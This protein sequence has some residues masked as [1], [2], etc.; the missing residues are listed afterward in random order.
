[1]VVL[2]VFGMQVVMAAPAPPTIEANS[3]IS[4]TVTEGHDDIYDV[5]VSVKGKDPDNSSSG[6]YKETDVVLVI[7]TSGSMNTTKKLPEA[8]KSAKKFVD[9][10]LVDGSKVNVAIVS[11]NRDATLTH[12]LSNNKA[13]LHTAIDGLKTAG[14]TQPSKAIDIAKSQFASGRSGADKIMVLLSDGLPVGESNEKGINAAAALPSNVIIKTIGYDIS[15]SGATYLKSVA[16]KGA[17]PNSG[18]Y[19]AN[20]GDLNNVFQEIITDLFG[21]VDD[22][23]VTSQIQK[24]FKLV[25]GSFKVVQGSVSTL[26]AETVT[27]DANKFANN[28]LEVK[29]GP[30][31][32]GKTVVFTYQIQIDQAEAAA[33]T[34]NNDETDFT[35]KYEYK[36]NGSTVTE[37]KTSKA[38][39]KVFKITKEKSENGAFEGDAVRYVGNGAS[40]KVTWKADEGY[41]LY[42]LHVNGAQVQ[43]VN[44]AGHDL[45]N[46]TEDKTIKAVYGKS[47]Q[48]GGNNGNN[49]TGTGT[50]GNGDGNGN[51]TDNGNGPSTG[52]VT[53]LALIT[54]LLAGSLGGALLVYKKK[55][56]KAEN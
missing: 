52:D 30:L 56:L 35:Y 31:A 44:P 18:Y 15:T 40:H 23:K 13:A 26:G 9:Q 1:M 54:L 33:I 14:N 21:A 55:I 51:G 42:E 39:A 49:G 17:A 19:D 11:F 47:R 7:D 48:G 38:T 28:Q 10:L 50:N 8:K 36:K 32:N 5:T 22:V 29:T 41:E 3:K 6:L 2:S 27:C 37:T 12:A 43:G 53:N 34:L 20:I 25:Q 46:I 24:P 4:T 45:S 16:A